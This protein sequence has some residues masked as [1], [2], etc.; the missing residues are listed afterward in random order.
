MMSDG[1][2]VYQVGVWPAANS[3]AISAEAE[4]E[5]VIANW[6][7]DDGSAVWRTERREILMGGVSGE[8]TWFA[9]GMSCKTYRSSVEDAAWGAAK[10]DA[11]RAET[12]RRVYCILAKG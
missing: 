4:A 10:T 8:K 12:A 3:E 5:L 9:T 1:R 11:A 6:T 7:R 2:A